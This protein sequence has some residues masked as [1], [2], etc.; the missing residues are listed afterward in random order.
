M[1]KTSSMV[2]KTLVVGVIVMLIG[3]SVGSSIG[4]ILEDFHFNT[5][6]LDR[7]DNSKELL[8]RGKNA[9]A[10]WLWNP[11]G[12]SGPCY[13]KLDDPGNI[14]GGG[15]IE[16]PFI[17][18]GTWTIDDR[19]IVCDY[20][21]GALFGIDPVTGDIWSIGG[22]GTSCN[23][24]AWDPVNNRLFGTTGTMLIEY[25]PETG[26]QE[27][28]GSHNQPG[29]TMISLAINLQGLCYVWDALFNGNS[30]LFTVDL[31]T[32]EATEIGDMGMNLCY[33]QDGAFDWDTGILY[34]SAF[35]STGFLAT[36]DVE[37]GELTVIG[38]FWGGS[39][40]TA[41]AIPYYWGYPQ[42]E[43]IWTPIHPNPG[44]MILFDASYSYDPDGYI[45]LYQW[46][47]DNDGVFDENHTS[48]TSTHTF[49]EAGYY[50]VTLRI[51]D[52][53]DIS[54][55]TDSKTK[56]VRVNFPPY[57]P[58]IEGKR[59]FKEGEGGQYPYTIYS[60]DPDEDDVSYLINWS[61][62]TQQWTG[63]YKSGEE[64][65]INV[66]IPQLDKGTYIIFKVKA[67]DVNGTESDWAVLEI[68]V[69][70]TR[71]SSLL[72][73]EWFLDCFPLLEKMLNILR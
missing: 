24:L 70:R 63:F 30:T 29:K 38:D 11:F 40:L 22:G 35:S 18:G 15:H 12:G 28:I 49:E 39:E 20:S 5:Q 25:D 2:Y 41:L 66:T 61:D 65:T 33:A 13:F 69:P 14:T 16:Y 7:G 57:T 42:A 58:I 72:W 46:D 47:W 10:W 27:F 48:P 71:P 19:W 3:M 59:R 37:T 32:G 9:Y 26:E 62:G 36:C 53:D 45:T 17:V 51:V 21:T 31:E 73:F 44:E 56:T 55:K 68:T 64:F 6:V 34:L 1:V 23:G 54:N 52:N 50:P 8:F 67:K 43:F 60:I 4:Y